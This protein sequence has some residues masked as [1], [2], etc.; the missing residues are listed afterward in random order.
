VEV[1]LEAKGPTKKQTLEHKVSETLRQIGAE[2]KEE[3]GSE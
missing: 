2:V 1:I 3:G